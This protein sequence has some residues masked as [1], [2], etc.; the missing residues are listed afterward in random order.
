MQEDWQLTQDEIRSLRLERLI[1]EGSYGKVHRALLPSTG[2]IYAV[3]VIEVG[4]DGDAKDKTAFRTM[5]QEVAVLRACSNC[6]Q[7]VRIIGVN[8]PT[9]A[10][11]MRLM[12]VME[13]CDHGSVQDI[14]RKLQCPLTEAEIR[15]IVR[16]VLIGLKY[17]H[18]GKLIHRDIKAG[19]ILVT[20]EFQPKLADFGISCQLQN[21]WARRNTQIGSP[22]WMAP[23]VIKGVTYNAKADIW[24]MGIT[25][26][27][28]AES[29]PPYFHIPPTRAMFV[30]SNKPPAGFTNSEEFSKDFVEFAERCLTVDPAMR[31][32]AAGL[33]DLAFA[34]PSANEGSAA[35]ALEKLMA[36]RLAGATHRCT[37]KTP[38]PSRGS[39]YARRSPSSNSLS[40]TTQWPPTQSMNQL[41]GLNLPP[42]DAATPG[43]DAFAQS[44][45]PGV[46]ISSPSQYRRWQADGETS[47]TEILV[48]KIQNDDGETN[49]EELRRRAREW[50]NRT[51]PMQ[52]AE[53]DGDSSDEDTGSGGAKTIDVKGES[54]N[55]AVWDSDEEGVETRVRKEDKPEAGAG[56]KSFMQVLG[57]QWGST[58]AT[59]GTGE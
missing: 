40:L 54:T 27:E 29:Q 1:G 23:E 17:L 10:F 49:N 52:L 48:A 19:N 53:D 11:P 36:P 12:V 58:G 50:V 35:E 15:I 18:D 21:T 30:I 7:I 6:P 37:D 45:A 55:Y 13:L 39:S 47:S 25:C 2:A 59:G 5:E 4:V 24:S 46:S 38:T 28:A 43:V 32:S 41:P 8:L 26:I 22:Y 57:K 33:L 9:G 16:E 20:K 14:L 34:Q 44:I 51:V 42:L 31:P 3:K 56:Y